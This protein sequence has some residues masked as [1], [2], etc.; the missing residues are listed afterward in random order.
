MPSH[1]QCQYNVGK[2]IG[3]SEI[4]WVFCLTRA[5]RQS[6]HRFEEGKAALRRFAEF[7]LDYLESLDPMTDDGLNDLHA[8]FGTVCC[9]AELQSALPGE[10]TSEKPMKLVLDRRPFI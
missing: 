2:N 4:D 5:M 6:P 1:K 8:L 7:F 3:F 9:L 10:I